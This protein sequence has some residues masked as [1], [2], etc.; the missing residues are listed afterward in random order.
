MET[1]LSVQFRRP[2]VRD[3]KIFEYIATHH[4]NHHY[5]ADDGTMWVVKAG[6]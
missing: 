5:L 1:P 3:G 6:R 4:G 2:I